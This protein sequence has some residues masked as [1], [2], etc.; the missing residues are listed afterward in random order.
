MMIWL[1]SLF[2]TAQAGTI[3]RGEYIMQV[4]GCV[5][6]HTAEFG[7]YL[8]GGRRLNTPFGAFY[9]PN[10]TPDPETGIGKWTETQF[11][12]AVRFGISPSGEY[13][14]PA[15]PYRAYSQMT[16]EDIRELYNHLKTVPPVRNERRPHELAFPYNQRRLLF[17]WRQLFFSSERQALGRG[18]Y[19]VEALAHCA[20]CHTPRNLL[21]GLIDS[22]WM[23]G[24]NDPLEGL[25]IPNI[26][27]DRWTGLGTWTD[28]DWEIFI[29]SGIR[30][31]R[32]TVGGEMAFVV[33]GLAI[34]TESDRRAVVDYLRSLRPVANH[35]ERSR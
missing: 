31:D 18:A 4:A 13:Y 25:A 9:V 8:A 32:S 35:V 24:T 28:K 19:L 1:L 6:C 21:G 27:P 12:N 7:Q 15:F 26:T 29:S 16:D 30:P 33:Q 23:A 20:E 3:T 17:F 2:I 22:M 5:H 11:Y 14:Y 10:I 34:L